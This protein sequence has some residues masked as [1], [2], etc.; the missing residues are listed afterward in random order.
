MKLKEEF[1]THESDGK[2]VLIDMEGNFSGLVRSNKT[3]AFIIE[4]LKVETTQ[5]AIIEKML[6]KYDAPKEVIAKDVSK[7]IETLQRIGAL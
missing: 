2:Q 3:A 4:C 5:E 1:M 6:K 7:V